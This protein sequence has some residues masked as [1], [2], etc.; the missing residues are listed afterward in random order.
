MQYLRNLTTS[1][2]F[3]VLFYLILPPKAYAYLDPGTGSYI[4]QMTIAALLGGLFVVKKF[5]YRF[6]IFFKNFLS[7]GSKLKKDED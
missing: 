6:K 4:L 2:I 7:G 3:L 5:W 1:I